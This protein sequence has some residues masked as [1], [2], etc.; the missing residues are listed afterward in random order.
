MLLHSFLPSMK[1]LKRLS[2]DISTICETWYRN[3]LPQGAALCSNALVYLLEKCLAKDDGPKSDV[4]RVL[5]LRDALFHFSLNENLKAL[6]LKAATSTAFTSCTEGVRF[7]AFLFSLSPSFVDA[8]N[9]AIKASL[10][11]VS[12][13]KAKAYG[14]IY[15]KAWRESSGEFRNRIETGAIQHFMYHAVLAN[16]SLP[17]SKD[18]FGALFRILE[19]FHQARNDRQCQKTICKLWEAI[20]WRHLNVAN[21]MVRGNAVELLCSAFPVE[22]PDGPVAEREEALQNQLNHLTKALL[23][24]APSVRIAAING[25]SRIAAVLW[26]IIPSEVLNKWFNVLV[27]DLAFDASSPKVRLA[28]I[29]GLKTLVTSCP[30]SHV[31]LKKVLPRVADTIHDVNESVRAAVV[32]LL[33]EV[34]KVKTIT[35]FDVCSMDHILARLE[36]DKPNVSSRIVSLIFNS[37]FPNYDS[38]SKSNETQFERCLALIK[39]NRAASRKFYERSAKRIGLHQAV[40]FILTILVKLKRNVRGQILQQRGH[41]EDDDKENDCVDSS[42][43]K[44]HIEDGDETDT[45]ILSLD[46]NLNEDLNDPEIVCGLLDVVSIVWVLRSK[47]LSTPASAEYRS[48][49]EKKAAKIMTMLFKFYRGTAAVG[50]VVY[51]CSLLPHASA[52]TIAGFCLSKLK[53]ESWCESD[54]FNTYIDALCNWGRGDDLC[55]TL[56]R[57]LKKDVE[58]KQPAEKK[59]TRGRV[60]FEES[61]CDDNDDSK[62]ALA[63]GI[64]AY[65]LKHPV[66]RSVLLKKN[67]HHLLEVRETLHDYLPLLAKPTEN[68]E[69]LLSAFDLL[70]KSTV[71]LHSKEAAE[72]TL[73]TVEDVINFVETEFLSRDAESLQDH[74]KSVIETT[75]FI[76]CNMITIG[77]CDLNFIGHVCEMGAL[78]V[79]KMPTMTMISH[80]ALLCQEMANWVISRLGVRESREQCRVLFLNG[81]PQLLANVVNGVAKECDEETAMKNVKPKLASVLAFYRDK[82]YS[83][84]SDS[85]FNVV[86]IFLEA[87]LASGSKV[88][89]SVFTSNSTLLAALMDELSVETSKRKTVDELTAVLNLIEALPDLNT[90]QTRL[91]KDVIAQIDPSEESESLT[92][93]LCDLKFRLNCE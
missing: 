77:V 19:R 61:S 28:V 80:C 81:I 63:L 7:I 21:P 22:D 82:F 43:K 46:Q 35:Y 74:I 59:V 14:D 45:S 30:R 79:Q 6:L 11:G 93:R 88:L 70:L 60:R 41:A 68:P 90:R 2:A 72:E 50:P 1:N 58:M 87:I 12:G 20:L 10:P 47:E 31:T 27:K 55:E 85:F 26:P 76:A 62:S 92:K 33:I 54:S 51:L 53:S 56:V 44:D 29:R 18:L 67:R 36:V 78:A 24:D 75:A 34:K 32:D 84:E 16:R 15:M 49:L 65:V 48:L 23:D 9:A 73:S 17:K 66:N 4:K 38:R 52:A 5:A 39:M 64:L 83:L 37:F 57:W 71:L 25:V 86:N 69:K 8:L 91:V 3:G 89:L 13:A 40:L 42:T